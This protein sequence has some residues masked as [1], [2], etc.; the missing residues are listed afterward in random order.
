MS[1]HTKEEWES[2]AGALSPSGQALVDG[3]RVSALSGETFESI[4]PA[5]DDVVAKIAACTEADID[6]AVGA[7]RRAFDRGDWSTAKPIERKRAVL[8]LAGLLEDTAD[9]LALLDSL[10]MGKLVEEA[11]TID[12]PG[13][14]ETFVWFG[15]LTDKVYGEVAPTDSSEVVFVTREPLGVIGCVVPWNYPFEIAAWKIAPAL[16]AGNS[17]VLKPASTTSL[18][19]LR[20]G[21]L[22]LEAGIPPGVLNVVPGL[23]GTAGQALGRHLDV[24]CIGFTGSTEVGKLF[25]RYAAESNMKQV[26]LETGGKSPNIVFP[27]ANDLDVVAEMACTGFLFNQGEVCSANTRLL[28]DRAVK[29]ELLELIGQRVRRF[30]PGNPLDPEST[31]GALATKEHTER[32]MSYIDIGRQEARLVV[33]GE[34]IVVKGSDCFV[35]P[36]IFDEAPPHATIVREEIFGPVLAVL[37]FWNEDEAIRMANDSIY[38]LAAS[39]WTADLGRAHRVARGL[40][41]GTVSVNTMDALSPMTPF[42]GFKQSGAGRD[43][44]IH[45]LEK[46]TGLKTTWI[47]F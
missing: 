22:A 44:S 23:G 37:P 9:E 21:D 12:L 46:Y 18:S 41:A 33:G 19:A 2:M 36:T 20:L 40:R 16:A 25:L 42:G 35:E 10:E 26:W 28:V 39:L 38:G 17:I 13:A 14:I 6:R 27:D 43:L 15:E 3:Q 30:Q 34:R 24:D 5:T 29:D 32:V 7:A 8:R 47:R 45:A 31:M 4:N 1:M 11:R